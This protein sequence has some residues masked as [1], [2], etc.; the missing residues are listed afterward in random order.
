MNTTA[1]SVT[2]N[3]TVKKFVDWTISSQADA[4]APEGSTT[5]TYRLDQPMKS[6]ECPAAETLKI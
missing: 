3:A 1:Q 2:I 6:H 4:G 5:R